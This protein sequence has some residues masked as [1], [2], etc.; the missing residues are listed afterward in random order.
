MTIGIRRWTRRGKP[1]DISHRL[2]AIRRHGSK[3]LGSL[4][5]NLL[6]KGRFRKVVALALLLGSDPDEILTI[7]PH[8]C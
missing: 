6:G 3:N 4:E 8:R 1:N 5:I 2:A 7:E